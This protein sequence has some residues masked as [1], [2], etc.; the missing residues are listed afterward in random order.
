MDRQ[1]PVKSDIVL[2]ATHRRPYLNLFTSSPVCSSRERLL[3]ALNKHGAGQH[4]DPCFVLGN[5]C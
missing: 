4:G 5:T 3:Q 1:T 2:F